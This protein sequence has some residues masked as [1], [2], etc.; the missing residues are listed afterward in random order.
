MKKILPTLGLVGLCSIASADINQWERYPDTDE[1]QALYIL[2][3]SKY[4]E[5]RILCNISRNRSVEH[6]AFFI[7]IDGNVYKN[8]NSKYPVTYVFNDSVKA[9]PA[10]T[11][12]WHNGAVQWNKFVQGL[13]VAT[14]IDVLVNNKKVATFKPSFTSVRDVASA[15]GRCESMAYRKF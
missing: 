9:S 4:D 2:Q 13:A 3:N 1:G 12:D 6:G 15:I 11:T 8:T 14:K 7:N 5:I 10:G